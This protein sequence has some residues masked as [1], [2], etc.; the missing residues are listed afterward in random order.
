MPTFPRLDL[1]ERLR[2]SSRAGSEQFA[3]AFRKRRLKA[4]R[5]LGRRLFIELLEDRTLLAA[6][7]TGHVFNDRNG[8][9]NQGSNPA[10]TGATVYLDLN[11]NGKFDTQETFT[12]STSFQQ[13]TSGALAGYFASPIAVSGLSAQFSDIS[14]SLNLARTGPGGPLNLDVALISP[15]GQL[16]F[17]GPDLIH[18]LA[19][20]SFN[21]TFND[22]AAPMTPGQASYNGT[23][24]PVQL[25]T[26]S[27]SDVLPYPANGAGPGGTWRLLLADAD[28][29]NIVDPLGVTLTS[30]S[31][32]FSNPEL[33][34]T[35]DASGNYSFSGLAAGSYTVGVAGTASAHD[36]TRQATVT[37]GQTTSGI[38]F[39]VTPAPGSIAGTVVNDLNANGT[40]DSGE[41]PV[42]GASVYLDLNN[43]GKYDAPKTFSAATVNGSV[44]IQD[45]G[46]IF[47]SVLSVSGV[48][49]QFSHL[50]TTLKITRNTASNASIDLFLA[51]TAG[52]NA[53]A[54]PELFAIQSGTTY[55][56]TLDDNAALPFSA[57]NNPAGGGTFRP[58]QP[59]YAQNLLIYGAPDNPWYLLFLDPNGN[60]VTPT[61]VTITSWSLTF[62][63]DPSTTTDANGNYSFANL[64]T[65]TYKVAVAGTAAASDPSKTVTLSAAV[66][67]ATANLAVQPVLGSV[68]GRVVNGNSQPVAGATTYLD[69]NNNGHYDPPL[70]FAGS[71]A[72][73]DLGGLDGATATVSGLSAQFTHISVNL[74]IS[75]AAGNG[76]LWDVFLASPQ[77]FNDGNGPELIPLSTGSAFN[78]TLDD[79]ASTPITS[80]SVPFV[81]TFQPAQAFSTS[82]LEVYGTNF[83]NGTWYL[84]FLDPNGNPVPVSGVTL[85][86]WSLN[87]IQEPSTTTDANGNYS[88]TGLKAGSYT[89]G[90]AGAVAG[91]DPRQSAGVTNGHATTGVNFT[92]TPA[93]DLLATSLQ[94]SGGFATW[95]QT[96]TV[97]YTV[98]NRG[99]G[100]AAPFQVDLRLSPTD[101]VSASNTL[102][103]SFTIDVN[104]AIGLA[105]GFSTSGSLTV[106]LPGSVIAP[107]TG[108]TATGPIYLGLVVDPGNTAAKSN[109]ANNSNQGLGIDTALVSNAA[110]TSDANAQQQPTIVVD[111]NNPNHIVV[112][113]MNFNLAN[114]YA[115]I[116]VQASTDGGRSWTTTSVPLPAGF[117]GAAGYPSVAFDGQG[118]VY[119]AFMAATFSPGL[120]PPTIFADGRDGSG[121][122]FR[123]YGT[124]ANNGIFLSVSGDG[125]L[126]WN[127]AIPV[128][129]HTYTAGSP[130]P[131]EAL[132]NLAIDTTA[133]LPNGQPNPNRG[134]LYVTW[135]RYYPVGQMP[136]VT[137]PTGGSDIMFA[138][139]QDGG[140]TWITPGQSVFN[141]PVSNSIT[142]GTTFTVNFTNKATGTLILNLT[143]GSNLTGGA[144]RINVIASNG[145]TLLGSATT[146]GSQVATVALPA[147]LNQQ[148]FL[149]VIGATST[150]AG[151]FTLQV[152][153]TTGL[154]ALRDVEYPADG[155]QPVGGGSD[156]ISHVTVG[157]DGQ[158]TIAL[159]RGG[160]FRVFGST[161]GGTVFSTL[162]DPFGDNFAT[163]APNPLADEDFRNFPVREIV[164][165]PTRPGTL[166]A[167]EVVAISTTNP[168]DGSQVVFARSTDDGKTWTN[169]F[170]VGPNA[171]STSLDDDN[172]GQ[173]LNL[174][175]SQLTQV[176]TGQAMPTMAVDNDGNV[177]V[178]WYDTR[179]DPANHDLDVFGVV[180]TDGG[181]TFSANYR[182]SDASIDPNAGQF[183]EGS[184]D[185]AFGDGIGLAA[186]NG[187]DLAVWTDTRNGNQ[188]IFFAGY[189]VLPAPTAP[190]DRF[191]PNDLPQTAT[192]LGTI[193]VP[194]AFPLLTLTAG[195]NDWYSLKAASSGD[196]IVSVSGT[197]TAT[198]MTVELWDATGST[199]LATA[200]PI[201]SGGQ[202]VEQLIDFAGQAGQVY[203]VHVASPLTGTNSLSYSLGVESLTADLGTLVH[204]VRPDTLSP[205]GEA[206]Y[207]VVPAVTGSMQVTLTAGS[208]AGSLVLET[209]SADGQSVVQTGQTTGPGVQSVSI[210]AIAGQAILVAV[211]GSTAADGGAYSLEFSNLDQNETP[212]NTTLFFPAAGGTPTALAFA[213]LNGDSNLDLVTATTNVSAGVNVLLNKGN[214]TFGASQSFDAGPGA[215]GSAAGLRDLVV[216]NFTADN[217]PD[218]IVTNYQAG[219]VSVLLGNG[220]GTLQPPR[221]FDTTSLPDAMAS[222][223]L[224]GDGALD[225]AVLQRLPGADGV[226]DVAVLFG[227]GD[228]TFLPPLTLATT[229]T[230]GAGQILVGDFSGHANA[231]SSLEDIAVFGFNEAVINLFVNQGN[232][233]FVRKVLTAPEDTASALAADLNNDGNLDLILGGTNS[234][235]V[236]V[237]MGN[238][239]GTFQPAQTYFANT[240][241][242]RTAASISGLALAAITQAG[243]PNPHPDLIVTAI[244]RIGN[245]S[246][247]IVLLPA[248]VDSHGNFTGFNSAARQVLALGAFTGPIAAGDLAKN[249]V[250]DVVAAVPGGV[251]SIYGKRPTITPNSTQAT[252]R[253]LGTVV[254]WVSPTLAI[255]PGHTDAWFTITVPKEAVPGAGPEV[256]DFS[257]LFQY[258]D[259]SGLGFEVIG[260]NGTMSGQRFEVV[261]SA[262]EVLTL[263]VFG[264]P[265]GGYGAYTLDIDVRPQ[266][267][268]V[269]APSL[270][271]GGPVS[272]LVITFQG[273]RLD[274]TTAQNPQNYTLIYLNPDGQTTTQF[275][276][277]TINDGLPVV[278]NPGANIDIA[279][280]L[281]YPTAVRQT[282]TLFFPTALPAG[283]YL[284]VLSPAIQSAAYS[285]AEPGLLA[286]AT[287]FG[288]HTVVSDGNPGV[289]DGAVLYLNDLVPA[290]SGVGNFSTFASGTGFLTNFHDTLGALLNAAL[291]SQGDDP[292]ITPALLD[293]A[294]AAF[295]PGRTSGG[296]T[297]SFLVLFLDPVGLSLVDPQTRRTTFDLQTNQVTNAQPKTYV[298]VGGNIEVVIDVDVSGL[299]LLSV[300]DVDST[301]RGGALVIGPEGT[302]VVSLT[303]AM[304]AGVQ[305]FSFDVPAS[306]TAGSLGPAAEAIVP[307]N[308]STL[309]SIAG[310]AVEIVQGSTTPSAGVE[311]TQAPVNETGGGLSTTSESTGTTTTTTSATSLSGG[312]DPG[313]GSTQ[314]FLDEIKEKLG[315]LGKVLVDMGKR[316]AKQS[317]VVGKG[318]EFMQTLG[319]PAV[320]VPLQRVG[321]GVI[322]ALFRGLGAGLIG[323]AVQPPPPPARE[324][325]V[326]PPV[327]NSPEP[328]PVADAPTL[329]LAEDTG[330]GAGLWL[331]AALAGGLVPV[332]REMSRRSRGR[333]TDERRGLPPP[334][335][336]PG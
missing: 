18:L 185:F 78:V 59:L 253:N 203:L 113:Y 109:T 11:G 307:P 328:A 229:L 201:F 254:H 234:G 62:T 72:I 34:T 157:P 158:V 31:M 174:S 171:N 68:S 321:E 224:N 215:T 102:L 237:L 13:I 161:D 309:S 146:L 51:S 330:K 21:G 138:Y 101:Q 137:S 49:N 299:F 259:G 86:S 159:N 240:D 112:A 255:V 70:T 130:V 121:N 52:L 271:P 194:R 25:F 119:V 115:S 76:A 196:L 242:A 114:G 200:T 251:D 267:V 312:G 266:A 69:L 4:Q 246:P 56:I 318:W 41:P 165:D 103:T 204:T 225:L 95:G 9:G 122:L 128:V 209:L 332:W 12:G 153:S 186:V 190:N 42:A 162:G 228:G 134:R 35:T 176:I 85:L 124:Q 217:Q 26:T 279:T 216:G 67:A 33:S 303:D 10:V 46:G 38:N 297:P 333:R 243:Q 183:P 66:P 155:A 275:T 306:V 195:D 268:S 257:A 290:S 310:A 265:G 120:L 144:L 230:A 182:V 170:Q 74:D 179:R 77:G 2:G 50:T 79:S 233:V 323:P 238:G 88:F 104:G 143:P 260:P 3:A 334:S 127:P 273:D 193:S 110:L 84:L 222:G 100:N 191:E 16:D 227:R 287:S 239:D 241:P 284:L 235:N 189:P 248:V 65:G 221:T 311:I 53:S 314:T 172:G 168:A 295:D 212:Q 19:G 220:N 178:I 28:T 133:T 207:R 208:G 44:P 94:V 329:P 55:S 247:Q 301:S 107:P 264:L 123:G 326:P 325:A 288:A 126:T 30:W 335:D 129:D 58:A 270:L 82:G 96:I 6:S 140:I 181:Q 192:N 223:N 23:F 175:A 22:H 277:A 205:G 39:G 300:A 219:S 73:N 232:G 319:V 198:P 327:E 167:L 36:P 160:L 324:E 292:G 135:T 43:N 29:G 269:A 278:Y 282:V 250:P 164:A 149:Q 98:M 305:N 147:T 99:L 188:D 231:G 45:L 322:R 317:S 141:V 245:G 298:E 197:G 308:P 152:V 272:S 285:V 320:V 81:G 87:F 7:I 206:I 48:E 211:V 71:T 252:A 60:P 226:S 336:P 296:N 15:Q 261:A 244:P 289:E 54:G 187:I 132:P 263:H 20:Q 180:S 302:Q 214:G 163:F 274:P 24:Q 331:A 136:G 177:S 93:P 64:N 91:P 27:G 83:P 105:A 151:N 291:T 142:A 111:P 236:Y 262:G 80:A 125:G 294:Q 92:V 37:A 1:P 280:G 148:V 166:Y 199:L 316:A 286:D 63:Q 90:V 315:P 145:T 173:P 202:V 57:N 258:T 276:P 131:F 213:D 293:Q 75:R 154:P 97:N 47:G 304:R 108:F 210:S 116:G 61:G 184:N 249:G 283:S 8:D 313:N 117:S 32:A 169:V 139:S 156:D 17:A 150:A 40:V 106:T 118:R 89:V 5:F 14:V 218:V 256:I 281:T